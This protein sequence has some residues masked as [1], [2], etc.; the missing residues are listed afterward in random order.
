MRGQVMTDRIGKDQWVYVFIQ[1]PGG[2]EQ[3]FGL[4]DEEKD[5]SF[6]PLFKEKED[7]LQCFVNMPKDPGKRYE[8]QAVQVDDLQKQAGRQG[9][10]LYLLDAAGKILDV[11][12]Q[13][14]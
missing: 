6:I 8:A 12:D 13:I 5:V 4:R 7:A 11:H 3:F 2:N 14:M 10:K 9:F 1:D